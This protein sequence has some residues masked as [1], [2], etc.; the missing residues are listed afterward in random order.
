MRSA[1]P[2]EPAKA[3]QAGVERVFFSVVDSESLNESLRAVRSEALTVAFKPSQ[4]D[5]R[6]V[7]LIDARSGPVSD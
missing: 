5:A 2:N 7:A 4:Y 6:R 3:F 1:P